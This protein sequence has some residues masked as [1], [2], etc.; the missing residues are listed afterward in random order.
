MKTNHASAKN[1]PGENYRSPALEKIVFGRTDKL[2]NITWLLLTTVVALILFFTALI[3]YP[4]QKQLNAFISL[5]ENG[6]KDTHYIQAS[7]QKQQAMRLLPGR[8]ASIIIKLEQGRDLPAISGNIEQIHQ[9]DV[10]DSLG[11]LISVAGNFT[12]DISRLSN[13]TMRFN[14][15]I[16]FVDSSETLLGIVF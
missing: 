4:Q 5:P 2:S 1:K 13:T 10:P 3:R 9:C 6:G 7:V 11:L 14:A 8:N 16:Q 12:S 15:V